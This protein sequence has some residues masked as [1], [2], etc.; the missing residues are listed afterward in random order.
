MTRWKWV[1]LLVVAGAAVIA[2]VLVTGIHV[3]RRIFQQARTAPDQTPLTEADKRLLL[4]M[5]TESRRRART[6]NRLAEP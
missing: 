6:P 3:G 1:L 4:T 2:S 5:L